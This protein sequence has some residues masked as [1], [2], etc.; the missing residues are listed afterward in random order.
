LPTR[1]TLLVNLG[2]L[3]DQLARPMLLEAG[4]LQHLVAQVEVARLVAA[5]RLEARPL[6]VLSVRPHPSLNR[7][8]LVQV[9]VFSS[10]RAL[11]LGVRPW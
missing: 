6:G 4:N 5:A 3:L 7:A 1:Q 10:L 8:R 2:Q 11:V 9:T